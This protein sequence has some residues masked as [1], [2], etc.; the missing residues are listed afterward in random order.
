MSALELL[1]R[2]G[3]ARAVELAARLRCEVATVYVELVAA[4]AKGQARVMVDGRRAAAY[5][6]YWEAV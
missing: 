1:K 6:C 4:E 5:R 2:L 3:A